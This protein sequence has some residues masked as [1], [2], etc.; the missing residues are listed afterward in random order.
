MVTIYLLLIHNSAIKTIKQLTDD[1]RERFDLWSNQTTKGGKKTR[2]RVKIV[3]EVP[4]YLDEMIVPIVTELAMRMPDHLIEIPIPVSYGIGAGDIYPINIGPRCVGGLTYLNYG[5]SQIHF[6]P[7]NGRK[8]YEKRLPVGSILQPEQLV[9]NHL[10][11]LGRMPIIE[12]QEVKQ[13]RKWT[14][15]TL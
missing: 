8:V 11:R 5:E 6:A 1:Y 15:R 14:R 3:A 12:V 10:A 13:R 7:V 9:R 2:S 4:N